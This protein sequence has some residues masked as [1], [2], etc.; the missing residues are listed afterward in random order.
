MPQIPPHL[1]LLPAWTRSIDRLL[2]DARSNRERAQGVAESLHAQFPAAGAAMCRLDVEDPPAVGAWAADAASVPSWLRRFSNWLPESGDAGTTTID[3]GGRGWK[4]VGVP[5]AGGRGRTWGSALLAFGEANSAGDSAAAEPVL[6]ALMHVLALN[7]AEDEAVRRT[8]LLQEERRLLA[9]AVTAGDA[10]ISLVHGL[11]N[12]LNAMMLQAAVVQLKVQEPIRTEIGQIRKEVAATAARM[13]PLM[14]FRDARRQKEA[15]GDLHRAVAELLA[16]LPEQAT[17]LK[18]QLGAGRT[19]LKVRGS[20]L[21]R[22]LHHFAALAVPAAGSP[23]RL[24]TESTDAETQ[25]IVEPADMPPSSQSDPGQPFDPYA[26]FVG[27]DNLLAKLAFDSLLRVAGATVRLHSRGG[28]RFS[29]V[30]SWAA[31]T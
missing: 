25:L 19:K 15:D 17:G 12:S 9:D 5:I 2:G 26:D 14:Q 22:L 18:S 29:T 24:R 8:E 6:G 31:P 10:V 13:R 7:L 1:A 11:N 3:D 16:D 23:C 4:E 28:G 27:S 30:I 21:K 20:D